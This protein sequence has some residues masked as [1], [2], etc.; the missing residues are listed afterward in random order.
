MITTIPTL[1]PND[2]KILRLKEVFRYFGS[3]STPKSNTDSYYENGTIPWLNTTD[4]N[5]GIV[6]ETKNKITEIAFSESSLRIYPRNSIAIAMYGQGKTRGTVGQI[7]FQFT[8]N[9][10]SCIM[11]G[12]LDANETFILYWF[13][14]QYDEIRFINIGATQPNMNKD[15]I[16]NLRIY[17]PP[18]LE[19]I[20]I[21]HYLDEKTAALDRKIE[22]LEQKAHSYRQLLRSLINQTVCRGLH[23]SAPLKD[24]GIEWIGEIPE[25][26]EVKRGKD[27]LRERYTKGHG[28]LPL[29]AAS[30]KLGVVRKDM[31]AQRS[32]EAQKDFDNFKL[33]LIN[34]F[35]I[36]L[37]SFEGGFEIAHYKGIISPAYAVFKMIDGQIP[38]FYKF[39]FKSSKFISYLK[40]LIS[41]IRDGQTIRYS[42]V[43]KSF[44]P[45]APP[46]EQKAIAAYLDA[47]SET[48]NAIISNIFEQINTLQKLR[49]SLINEV[50]T[51]QRRLE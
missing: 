19:Q 24:S 41:G 11:Y 30:Q 32:M 40:T 15:F 50:V 22:L 12:P 20:R 4:L 2:W 49:K 26:W 37:R 34:D 21:A 25:H 13:R 23:P 10:A 48:I 16:R 14:N 51:G 7:N 39:L 18:L 44:F 36:S 3:G 9:Q 38:H 27:I 33:V 45:I 35:V 47:K 46:E 31:L 17:L 5:N 28:H 43:Q 29:L 42:E 8:T 1:V 6:R